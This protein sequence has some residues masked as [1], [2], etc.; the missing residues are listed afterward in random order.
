MKLTI[1]YDEIP[2]YHNRHGF[3]SITPTEKEI[4]SSI[5]SQ[6]L[7]AKKQLSFAYYVFTGSARTRFARSIGVL[8]V[9]EKILN[10]LIELED[11]KSASKIT[12]ADVKILRMAALLHDI[13]H[14]PFSHLI[15][16]KILTKNGFTL[17]E[18]K[19]ISL[20]I[21]KS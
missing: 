16:T 21:P 17:R 15:I 6:R 3:V 19:E 12:E 13:G 18:I 5:Y 8:A 10:R 2:I 4:I 7:I 20:I 11:E 9:V 14:N 1:K